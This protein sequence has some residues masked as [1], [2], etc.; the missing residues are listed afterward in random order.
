MPTDIH[1]PKFEFFLESLNF[2][3]DNEY[4]QYFSLNFFS[5]SHYSFLRIFLLNTQIWKTEVCLT[6]VLLSKN[7]VHFKSG[8]FSLQL[9]TTAQVQVLPPEITS[10]RGCRSTR[11][12]SPFIIPEKMET[13]G[14]GVNKI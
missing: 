8:S 12:A 11:C 7:G 13:Q 4:C 2:I 14:S 5:G 1:F 3:T 10:L 6:G 9:K